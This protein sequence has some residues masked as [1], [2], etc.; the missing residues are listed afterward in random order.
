MDDF[1][2]QKIIYSETNNSADTKICLDNEGYYTDKTCFIITS[3]KNLDSLYK[4][5]SSPVFT[6]Y[7]ALI[8]PLLGN[9]G[10]SLTKD[11]VELFPAVN[12]VDIKQSYHLTDEEWTYI[13]K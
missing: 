2:K 7:M 9:A 11:S 3:D 10:I 1:S 8:S 12:N 5:M 13:C 6:W 4:C